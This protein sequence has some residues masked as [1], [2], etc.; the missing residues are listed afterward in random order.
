LSQPDKEGLQGSSVEWRVDA[1]DGSPVRV[2]LGHQMGL[3]R[4]GLFENEKALKSR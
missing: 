2:A 1:D 4:P 3:E